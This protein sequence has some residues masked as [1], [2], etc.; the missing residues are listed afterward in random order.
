MYNTLAINTYPGKDKA[1]RARDLSPS[2]IAIVNAHCYKISPDYCT[3][4]WRALFLH[5]YLTTHEHPQGNAI[6]FSV[7]V[8]VT[9]IILLP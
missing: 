3:I 5:T 2:N 8:A 6:S 7:I 4:R 1:E 9:P